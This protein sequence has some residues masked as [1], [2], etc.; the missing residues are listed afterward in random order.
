MRDASQAYGRALD[1]GAWPI[2]T[3]AGVMELNI[4]GVH[5]PGDSILYFVDSFRDF[6]I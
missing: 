3:R 5:G 6:S 4:P 2:P 1:P